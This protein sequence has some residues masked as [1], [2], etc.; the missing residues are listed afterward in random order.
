[1][2]P[3]RRRRVKSA[4]PAEP[5][6]PADPVPPEATVHPVVPHPQAPMEPPPKKRITPPAPQGF[7]RR[8]LAKL[9]KGTIAIEARLDL[10]GMT[11]AEAH[12]A[13]RRFLDGAQARG[14]RMVLVITGKGRG[15]SG[16]LGGG[17]ERGVL[18]RVVPHWLDHPEFRT[19]VA[20]HQPAHISHGGDGALY[21]RVRR[22]R[23]AE[24]ETP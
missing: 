19:L 10:H 13:L 5:P 14:V 22:R 23:G 17:S 9:V 12:A 21:V 1:V 2:K 4:K 20:S 18:A 11:Q 15:G 8:T 7:D 3:L 16:L 6:A 24:D